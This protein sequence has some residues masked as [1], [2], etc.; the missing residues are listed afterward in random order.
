MVPSRLNL[1]YSIKNLFRTRQQ[2]YQNLFIVLRQSPDWKNLTMSSF[3]QQSREFCKSIGRPEDQINRVVELWD[4]TFGISFFETRQAMKEIALENFS[5]VTSATLVTL[6]DVIQGKTGPGVY[7]FTDD[8]DWICP[9]IL[10]RLEKYSS[11]GFAGFVWGSVSFGGAS[12]EPIKLRE[13]DGTCYTNN[14]AVTYSYFATS[15]DSIHNVYQHWTANETF[16]RLNVCRIDDYLTITNKNP[17]S[18]VYLEKA[19]Q[20]RATPDR[21]VHVICDYNKRLEGLAASEPLNW[22]TPYMLQAKDFYRKL[23]DSSKL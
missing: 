13:F 16:S 3:V 19:L 9:N 4:S 20:Q 21:L 6:A 7:L 18:T 8:D 1:S 17:S 12:G 14:Y 15:H 23:L 22:A 11:N 5:A 2:N 10:N